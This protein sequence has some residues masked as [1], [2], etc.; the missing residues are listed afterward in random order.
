MKRYQFPAFFLSVILLLSLW[1]TKASSAGTDTVDPAEYAANV[2]YELGLFRGVG[3]RED[4]SPDFDLERAPTREEAVTML[5]RLLGKDA[6]ANSG[7]WSTPFADVS[8]WAKPYVGYAYS[9]KLT[10]GVSA[11]SFGGSNSVTAT[12]YLT[13]VLRALGYSSEFDFSWDNAWE[14]S[15][16]LSITFGEYSAET[17]DFTRGNVAMISATSLGAAMKN[18]TDN[19]LSFLNV[20]GALAKTDLVIMDLEVVSCNPNKMGFVF[21]PISGSPNTYTSF[22]VN[23]V[24]VNTMPCSMQQY[25][26]SKD[27]MAALASLSS[28]YPETF[29]YSILSYDEAAAKA[30]ATHTLDS[31]GKTLPILIFSFDCTGTLKDGSTVSETFSEAVYIEGYSVT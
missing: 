9:H 15:D 24:T 26:S 25:K 13:F 7:T 10:Y 17:K 21:F 30:A 29:N 5:V 4:G 11:T 2:L 18:S 27:A 12:Q 16:A 19:L 3:N 22:Q 20:S 8:D 28:T 6:E 23:K 1:T 31:A 14:L